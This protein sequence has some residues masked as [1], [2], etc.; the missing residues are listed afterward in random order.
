[1]ARKRQLGD[2]GALLA[3]ARRLL[4]GVRH[5][6]DAEVLVVAADDL[7]ANR[8]AFGVKPAGT[9]AAGLPVAEIYQQDFIQ[10][11]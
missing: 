1:M 7:H 11:M 6:Q 2:G 5:L 8:Q 4:E 3:E 10:S 9:E